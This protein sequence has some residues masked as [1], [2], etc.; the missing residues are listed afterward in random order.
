[1]RLRIKTETPIY[2][3]NT[4]CNNGVESFDCNIVVNVDGAEVLNYYS[5]SAPLY[6]VIT[7]PTITTWEEHKVSIKCSA[8]GCQTYLNIFTVYGYDLGNTTEY[9]NVRPNFNI[10]MVKDDYRTELQKQ[11]IIPNPKKPNEFI[12]NPDYISTPIRLVCSGAI[13][14]RRP[15]TNEI[16]YYKNV[17][18][19][20]VSYTLL[21]TG[22]IFSTSENGI[23]CNINEVHIFPNYTLTD[24]IN[25]NCCSPQQVLLDECKPTHSIACDA[26]QWLPKVG[27]SYVSKNCDGVCV[28]NITK[29][30]AITEL[31]FDEITYLCIDDLFH[32]AFIDLHINK[33]IWGIGSEIV[34]DII[35]GYI[36][37][38]ILIDVSTLV[39]FEYPVDVKYSNYGYNTLFIDKWEFSTPDLGDY[40]LNTTIYY[41]GLVGQELVNISPVINE[42]GYFKQYGVLYC[43]HN[44]IITNKHWFEINQ[45]ECS[46]Y[47]V[48]NH[49]FESIT[50]NIYKLINGEFIISNTDTLSLCNS[51]EVLLLNDGIYKIE[52]IKSDISYIYVVINYCSIQDCYLRLLQELICCNPANDC[53]V[54]NVYNYN[55]FHSL[56]NVLMA[57]LNKEYS[58]NFIYSF[59]SLE[60][61]TEL[62]EIEKLINRINEEYCNTCTV[63]QTVYSSITKKCQ[64]CG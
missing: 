62:F 38:Y 46:K 29:N 47:K 6:H 56:V 23:L 20:T 24:V 36:D 43:E 49:S 25:N 8:Y 44:D 64:S 3:N 52:A 61:I 45:I 63:P 54:K 40:I 17:N 50:L 28:N 30:L 1:M 11:E 34:N 4:L 39:D 10:I 41:D 58:F 42:I 7:I 53:S 32:T 55:I 19:G 33:Q 51:V 59:I 9:F 26:A 5:G 48:T 22:E 35:K 27:Y 21:H 15:F 18:I 14:Y 37:S 57:Q 60:K 13:I 16:H 2:A 12:P 31:N